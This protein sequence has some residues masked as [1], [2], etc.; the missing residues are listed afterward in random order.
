[1]QPDGRAGRGI[2]ALRVAALALLAA[3]SACTAVPPPAPPAPAAVEQPTYAETGIA[4]WYGRDHQGKKTAAGERF[5]MNQLTAAHRTLPLNTT[6]RV[7]NIDNQKTVKVRINDR[8]PYVR[9]R[10]ID[11][12]SRAARALDIVDDGTAKVR[13]EVFAS[14]QDAEAAN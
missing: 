9:T 6:V 8:G 7:T 13:L 11:L 2:L 4:S 14:D 12:S 10:I 5:D 3:A 1:M